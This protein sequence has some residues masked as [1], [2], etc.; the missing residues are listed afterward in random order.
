MQG[1]LVPQIWSQPKFRIE[2][3]YL[4]YNLFPSLFIRMK[5]NNLLIHPKSINRGEIVET[6]TGPERMNTGRGM[7]IPGPETINIGKQN[8]TAHFL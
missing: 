4:S 3:T 5:K 6:S 1:D 7:T 2:Y 8:V